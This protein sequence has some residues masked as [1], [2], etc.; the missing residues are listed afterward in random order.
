MTTATSP[1]GDPARRREPD[2]RDSRRGD[3][4]AGFTLLELLVVITIIGL[5]YAVLPSG[6]FGGRE[7][8]ELRAT[9]RQVAEDLRRARGQ[10]IAG[11]REV[12]FLLDLEARRFGVAGRGALSEL[13]EG[14]EAKVLT[15]SEVVSDATQARI[16]FFPDG[17]S[18]GG[19][20][21][22]SGAGKRYEVTVRW[23]TGEVRLAE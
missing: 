2:R 7:G 23:L 20:V 12:A 22:L 11:N 19:A 17:S 13:P 8:V 3:P 9:A 6:V 18:T 16:Q 21:T 4:A 10:A 1:A 5:I 14:I 15:A